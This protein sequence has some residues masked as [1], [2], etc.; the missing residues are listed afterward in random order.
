MT[1]PRDTDTAARGSK[2][3]SISLTPTKWRPALLLL[4]LL[5]ARTRS[6][7]AWPCRSVAIWPDV[8][9][10]QAGTD[11]HPRR[12]EEYQPRLTNQADDSAQD[13]TT[14]DGNRVQ[15]LSSTHV[16]VLLK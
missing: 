11:Q 9:T 7:G 3:G 10:S 8:A 5:S 1:E 13:Q 16:L 4:L 12:D 6:R 14:L 15:L 2:R